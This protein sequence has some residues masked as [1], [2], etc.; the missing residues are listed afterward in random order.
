MGVQ[1]H[2]VS[3]HNKPQMGLP[4][5]GLFSFARLP[6]W[7]A[8]LAAG[9][10]L[11]TAMDASAQ[12]AAL[13]GTHRITL[14]SGDGQRVLIGHVTFTPNA[15]GPVRFAI[16]MDHDRFTDYFLS[17]RE[18][19]C[20]PGGTEILCHI[21]YPY[22]QPGTVT[23][24]QFAWLEHALMFMFKKPSDFGA[25]LWNG[26]YFQLRR[27]EQGL[28][29]RPQAV[30]LNHIAAPPARLDIPPFKPALRDDM[31]EAARWFNRLTI[32]P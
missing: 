7:R 2:E 32:E 3:L 19:K 27:S 9:W 4:R 20:L 17:M 1:A 31:P 10:L 22:A 30:D 15:E 25:K 12:A 28:V 16:K 24:G 26:V 13:Q 6:R 29:G 18:M 14:H 11:G 5:G 21:P 23:D 8:M